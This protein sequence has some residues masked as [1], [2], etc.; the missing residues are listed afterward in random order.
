MSLINHLKLHWSK[1]TVLERLL[2]LFPLTLV[3]PTFI[4]FVT[5]LTHDGETTHE[6]VMTIYLFLALMVGIMTESKKQIRVPRFISTE[7]FVCLFILWV[8]LSLFWTSSIGGTL[9]QIVIWTDYAVLMLLVVCLRR[10]SKIGLATILMVAAGLM[11]SIKLLGNSMINGEQVENS[12]L[13]KNLGVETE[14]LIT[15]IPIFWIVFLSA[16]RLR[17][18]ITSLIGSVLCLM[19]SLS[20][21]QRAPLLGIVGAI[22]VI[23]IYNLVRWVRPRFMVRAV[24]LTL[25]IIFSYSAQ[26]KLQ[27]GLKHE[28]L[29]DT[30]FLAVK[31]ADENYVKSSAAGRFILWDSALEMFIRHPILG[32]GAGAYKAEYTDYRILIN[33][34]SHFPSEIMKASFTLDQS[35]GAA[36]Y[37]RAHNEF[38][39]VFGELGLV[40]GL[41]L[42]VMFFLACLS[43]V[44]Q[45]KTFVSCLVM[46][47]MSAFVISSIFTSFSFRWI[48]CGLTFFL[49]VSLVSKQTLHHK[50]NQSNDW[51]WRWFQYLVTGCL[52]LC[53]FRS[54]QVFLSQCYEAKASTNNYQLALSIDPYNFTARFK[55]GQEYYR[56]KEAVLAVPLLEAA[57]KSGMNDVTSFQTLALAQARIGE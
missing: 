36:S 39:Q 35:D 1:Y 19:A 56:R 2:V 45:R 31:I 9:D 53:G 27:P 51:S 25:V 52:L 57:L 40:G 37:F 28:E 3:T 38:L 15:L 34:H 5:S 12:P 22:G 6:F 32:V 17:V 11:A 50:T 46:S 13:F 14:I 54:S 48:P 24:I 4:P 42:L 8:T 7:F 20:T 23:V 10:R 41:I 30:E 55:L 44:R 26:F 33:Q 29:S 18:V 43:L 21:Y 47:G 49:L 16:R